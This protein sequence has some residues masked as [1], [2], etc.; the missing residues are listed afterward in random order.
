MFWLTIAIWLVLR[1]IHVGAVRDSLLAGLVCGFAVANKYPA[2]AILAGLGVA[3]LE[4]RW[5]EGRSLWRLVLDLRPYVALYAAVVAFLCA[6]PYFVL[7]WE[8]TVKDFEYQRGFL[9]NGVGNTLAGW[10]WAWLF[11]KVLPHGFGL[12]LAALLL[13]GLVWGALRPRLGTPSLVAFVIVAFVGMTSSRYS[14]YRYAI[15]P[16]PGLAL[17]AGRLVADVA[18]ALAPRLRPARAWVVA[19]AGLALVLAPC[20][21]RDYKL[22]RILARR[23][24]RTI[25]REWIESNVPAPALIAASDHGTPYGKPQLPARYRW[26]ALE[27]LDALRAKGVQFVVADTSPLAFYSRGP[28]QEQLRQ[29]EAGA[30]LVLDLDPIDAG[31]RPPVFDMADAFYAP[32]QRASSMKRP[33]PRIRI[34]KIR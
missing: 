15:V 24:T 19:A 8:Q 30:D 20:V 3:H 34:W 4:A 12:P 25:A 5:R 17:L 18:H 1:V 11:E 2:G 9:E 28:T 7:D 29:L 33:G 23:D 22:N 13:A 6:T 27:P 21:I 32:L 10:G 31:A 14:F 26:V 16:L